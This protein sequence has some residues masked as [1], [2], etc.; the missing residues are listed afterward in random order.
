MCSFEELWLE[1]DSLQNFLATFKYKCPVLLRNMI[2][3]FG[4]PGD[5]TW[6]VHECKN[7]SINFDTSYTF[8]G[9]DLFNFFTY[10][11]AMSHLIVQ[12]QRQSVQEEF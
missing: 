8:T 12:T 1:K 5:T 3:Q 10:I 6:H 2:L 4:Q 7:K 9:I 11:R